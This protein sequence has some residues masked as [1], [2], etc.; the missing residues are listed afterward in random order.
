MVS[1]MRSV[2]DN[3][4]ETQAGIR[5]ASS[6]LSQTLGVSAIGLMKTEPLRL[7]PGAIGYVHA[8]N[9][10]VRERPVPHLNRRDVVDGPRCRKTGLRAAHR[11]PY[12]HETRCLVARSAEERIVD[13]R[14]AMREPD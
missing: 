14:V 2:I 4:V 9:H 11:E 1:G 5:Q 10:G 13:K 8:V 6:D 12:L 7:K 3:E